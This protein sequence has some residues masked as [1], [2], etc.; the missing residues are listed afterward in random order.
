MKFKS[1]EEYT[2][3]VKA[4]EAVQPKATTKKPAKKAPK[5]ETSAEKP[6]K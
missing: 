4:R 2:N 5:K 1:V 3:W 6:T